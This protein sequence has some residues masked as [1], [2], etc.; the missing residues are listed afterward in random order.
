MNQP[1]TAQ[2]NLQEPLRRAE[3]THTLPQ[4]NTGTPE[5][6]GAIDVGGNN[7]LTLITED[8]SLAIFQA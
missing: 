6:V 5:R 7:T 2:P 8:S 1:V 3:F 4:E